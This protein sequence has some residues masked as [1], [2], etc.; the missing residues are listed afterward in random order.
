[1]SE[2]R[3]ALVTG[4]SR[5][6]GAAIARQ[7]AAQGLA[8]SMHFN[9]NREAADTVVRSIKSSGGTACAFAGDLLHPASASDLIRRTIDRFGRL[10]V[11]VNNA[12]HI[13][14]E[15]VS[16]LTQEAIEQQLACN[17]SSVLMLSKAAAVFFPAK[18]III[19]M[20]SINAARPVPGAVVY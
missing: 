6:I 4:A 17:I 19:N 16:D 3:V 15:A 2:H 9:K 13:E 1:M 10:D 18:G 14:P 11:L 8:V 12:A 5:G 7:L 20:S